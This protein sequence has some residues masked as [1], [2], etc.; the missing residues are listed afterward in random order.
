MNTSFATKTSGYTLCEILVALAIIA[1]LLAIALP[2]FSGVFGRVDGHQLMS[3]L[4][5]SIT[6]ARG[7]A[8]NYELDTILCS[9]ADG[10]T[11]SGGVE[12][13]HGWIVG[14]DSNGDGTLTADEVLTERK[15]AVTDPVHMVTT[16]GRTRLQFQ[17]YGSNAGSNVTFTLC[18]RRGAGAASAYV[19]NNFGQF[20][21]A[22][23]KA[24]AIAKACAGL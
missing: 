19:L 7:A 4:S 24:A 5:A 2:A 17:P 13:H 6:N 3:S 8:M 22:K 9:S 16:S 14:V 20:H 23:P 11:C 21:A 18:D 15:T 10:I 12:W 1:V